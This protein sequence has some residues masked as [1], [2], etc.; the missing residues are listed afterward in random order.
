MVN[1]DITA[2]QIQAETV[3]ATPAQPEPKEPADMPDWLRR[4]PRPSA[5]ETKPPEGDGQQDG[6][7]DGEQDGSTPVAAEQTSVDYYRQFAKGFK[8]FAKPADQP[9]VTPK[10]A[11]QPPV[12]PSQSAVVSETF[13][14]PASQPTKKNQIARIIE[15]LKGE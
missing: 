4:N 1:P 8:K 6:V 12:D 9:K 7:P 11:E 2:G 14:Q 3:E 5:K 15:K 13:D 10:P